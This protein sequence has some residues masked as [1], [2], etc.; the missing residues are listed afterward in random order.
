MKTN[1]ELRRQI[2]LLEQQLAAA[3]HRN[4]KQ[5]LEEALKQNAEFRAKID[6]M[7]RAHAEKVSHLAMQKQE[8]IQQHNQSLAKQTDKLS[9][10]VTEMEQVREKLQ[11]QV[12]ELTAKCHKHEQTIEETTSKLKSVSGDKEELDARVSD[13]LERKQE[14]ELENQQ[15]KH[16]LNHLTQSS[17]SMEQQIAQYS[18]TVKLLDRQNQDQSLVEKQLNQY[19]QLYTDAQN[20]LDKLRGQLG[21][22]QTQHDADRAAWESKFQTETQAL[23]QHIS[24]LNDQYQE[25]LG[26]NN[27]LKEFYAAH[28]QQQLS[29]KQRQSE[30]GP[31]L[32]LKR[33]NIELREKMHQLLT[34]QNIDSNSA[35]SSG[36]KC[37]SRRSSVHKLAQIT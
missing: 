4:L 7:S 31:F 6:L 1:A 13:L 24:A 30:F 36:R 34:Q 12:A 21:K 22:I 23:Q 16:R 20:E 19:I 33:E 28:Q 18:E 14:L 25:L 5:E 27:R 29:L 8:L 11:R 9:T 17:A 37:S 2:E 10:R 35:P 26:E 3:T 32:E 15:M